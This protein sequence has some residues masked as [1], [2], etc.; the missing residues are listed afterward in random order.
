MEPRRDATFLA[1]AGGTGPERREYAGRAMSDAF[2][3]RIRVRYSECDLQG[4]VFNANYLTYL[5]EAVTELL[6]RSVEGAY[7]GMVAEG[8]DMVVAEANIRY[9]APAR[10]D[11]V[12]DVELAVSRL[13][14]T[15]MVTSYRVCRG[16]QTLAE[17][18]L[19]HVFVHAR[20]G[21]KRP[22]PASVRAGLEAHM[23]A[24]APAG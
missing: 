18:E 22:I 7:Q 19:R 6:R 12:V 21:G 23:A 24:A 15:S 3:H 2:H 9:L 13:G 5:D 11:D 16:E 4:V 1:R 8:A 10:F 20:E 17:A 14:T